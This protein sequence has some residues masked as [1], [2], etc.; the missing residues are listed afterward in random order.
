[1]AGRIQR[2]P[3]RG[4]GVN[5]AD[6][7]AHLDLCEREW[8]ARYTDP[9][10]AWA[11]CP[12]GDW[13]LWIA[14]KAGL[15]PDP[16][17]TLR[18][19]IAPAFDAAATALDALGVDHD[20]RAYAEQLRSE[21]TTGNVEAIADAAACAAAL[22]ACDAEDV[23]HAAEV[24]SEAY[25]CVNAAWSAADAAWAIVADYDAAFSATAYS[26]RVYL[27]VARAA[28]AAGAPYALADCARAAVYAARVRQSSAVRRLWPEPP[29][30]VLA[31]C[32]V[33]A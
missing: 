17:W 10:L 15:R 7:L 8:L 1:M 12:R 33:T 14:E 24:A 21:G 30:A 6:R 32:E 16:A 25:A 27:A 28:Y 11:E 22:A 29:P 18:E 26:A 3:F 9:R 31:L 23:A 20:L 4:D 19:I 5:L 2:R 13:L